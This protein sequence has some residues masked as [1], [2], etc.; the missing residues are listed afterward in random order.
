MPSCNADACRVATGNR[1]T[2][3]SQKGLIISKGSDKCTRRVIRMAFKFLDPEPLT[4][5]TAES[6]W[7]SASNRLDS[8]RA[9]HSL[10]ILNDIAMEFDRDPSLMSEELDSYVQSIDGTCQWITHYLQREDL[11]VR[12]TGEVEEGAAF[13][14]WAG[15]LA[16][17]H[18]MHPRIARALW[19]STAFCKLVIRMWAFKTSTGHFKM[20]FFSNAGCLILKLMRECLNDEEGREVLL[21]ELAQLPHFAKTFTVVTIRRCLQAQE[22]H[23]NGSTPRKEALDYVSSAMDV[24]LFSASHNQLLERA[25]AKRQYLK[26]LVSTMVS[27]ADGAS[28]TDVTFVYLEESSRR[29]VAL[30]IDISSNRVDYNFGEMVDGGFV[31]CIGRLLDLFPENSWTGLRES[32][33]YLVPRRSTRMSF[34]GFERWRQAS[35]V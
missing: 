34:Q 30:A 33:R 19:S 20:A 29:L 25:F 3:K 18:G 9:M 6:P 7:Y 10:S 15:I 35:K 17:T 26:H 22:D 1:L 28:R 16:V 21:R 27:L 11:N 32:Y 24:I 13:V 14:H 5:F 12:L 2:P 23:F 4:R 31:E 8:N